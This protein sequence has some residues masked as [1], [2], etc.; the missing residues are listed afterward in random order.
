MVSRGLP[1]RKYIFETE[2]S[3]NVVFSHLVFENEL[4][5]G[6][7][8]L[9]VEDISGPWEDELVRLQQSQKHD[10]MTLPPTHTHTHTHTRTHTHTHHSPPPPYVQSSVVQVCVR[11][12]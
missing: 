3:G 2:E 6:I 8:K 5:P 11:A 4:S 1:F 9:V 7:Y 12:R 10:N